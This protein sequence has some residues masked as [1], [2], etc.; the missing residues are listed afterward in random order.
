MRGGTYDVKFPTTPEGQ[1]H[2]AAIKFIRRCLAP[3]VMHRFCDDNELQMGLRVL[4]REIGR[5]GP[6]Q[7]ERMTRG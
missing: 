2:E 1:L 4:Q 6:R 5:G 7:T 3:E